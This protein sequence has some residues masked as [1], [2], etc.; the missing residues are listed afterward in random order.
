MVVSYLQSCPKRYWLVRQMKYRHLLY[1]KEFTGADGMYLFK[2]RIV[3][4]YMYTY[5]NQIL[6][7]FAAN[8]T[9]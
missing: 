3:C 8:T 4:T 9:V 2:V 5:L 6:V 7:T 1:T